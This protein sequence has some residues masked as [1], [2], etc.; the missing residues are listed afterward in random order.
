MN[1]AELSTS[2]NGRLKIKPGGPTVSAVG[3]LPLG[4]YFSLDGHAG[5]FFVDNKYDLSLGTE[6][7]S[8]S[9]SKTSIYLGAGAAWWITGQVALR[10]GYQLVPPTPCSTR[11]PAS[12]RWACAIRT[13]TE[14]WPVM[15]GGTAR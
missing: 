9:D 1:T 14:P 10:L 3:L 6:S 11:T 5:F 12:S 13:A 8:I 15:A 4:E 7:L 2:K